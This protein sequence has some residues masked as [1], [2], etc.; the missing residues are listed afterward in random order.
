M[1]I[2]KNVS[3]Y[4][5]TSDG[6]KKI[7][8]NVNDILARKDNS[9]KGWYCWSG[10]YTLAISPDG[11]IH[12][13]SCGDKKMGNIYK[14]SKINLSIKPHICKRTWC[15]CAAELNIKKIKDIKYKKYVRESPVK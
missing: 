6:I 9:Y 2:Y 13:A 12:G 10:I 3:N 1:S 4:V 15:V 5:E 7:D 8:E 11:T 14:D